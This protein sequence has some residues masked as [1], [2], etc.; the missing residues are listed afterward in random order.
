MGSSGDLEVQKVILTKQ[1]VPLKSALDCSEGTPEPLA[2][3]GSD[4]SQ[5]SS[6]SLGFLKPR[7]WCLEGSGGSLSPSTNQAPI[8]PGGN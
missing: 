8:H 4:Y 1:P 2:G 7:A 3:L 6:L 5:H